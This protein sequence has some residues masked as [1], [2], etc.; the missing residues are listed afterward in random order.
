[1]RG[2]L[3]SNYFLK[4]LSI[5]FEV[6]I[7]NIELIGDDDLVKIESFKRT[8]T[9]DLEI[10]LK[11]GSKIRIE[12]Q[13]GFQGINDIKQHKV[14][15]AKKIMQTQNIPSIAIH[16]DLFNGQVAFVP[17]D[18]IEDNSINWITRQQMEGQTVFNIDQNYFIWKLTDN[19]PKL[20]N[21]FKR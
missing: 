6:N 18:T 8:P 16:F 12:M 20:D 17:L 13:S 9:A 4:A 15:E 14:V 7:E 5:I 11:D 3:I 2:Y 19:P 10:S 1:M 21:L